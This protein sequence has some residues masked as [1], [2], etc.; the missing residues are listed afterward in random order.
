[1]Q[2]VAAGAIP[3]RFE[4]TINKYFGNKPTGEKTVYKFPA[5]KPLQKTTFIHSK[6]P[7]LK[8][9]KNPTE[10]SSVFHIGVVVPSETHNDSHAIW[11]MSKILGGD[12]ES[13]LFNKIREEK[14]L[15]YQIKTNYG[16]AYNSGTFNVYGGVKSAAQQKAID[17]IF[18]EF[19]R[20]QN[21][22]IG[23][24]ELGNVKERLKYELAKDLESNAGHV[25]AIQRKL[26]TGET[27][28]YDM[29]RISEITPERIMEV[30]QKY[31]P[32][33]RDKPHVLLL[34][35]PLKE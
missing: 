19:K 6:A 33:S 1:M 26:K 32:E 34:R 13:R 18:D 35:D 12:S 3:P 25:Q 15:A 14:G 10:S 8:N 20:M 5:H 17:Y 2:F 28:E 31:L 16:T 21:K 27:P 7:E 22:L 29:A 30:S 23:K 11:V 24:E 4:E 9:Q